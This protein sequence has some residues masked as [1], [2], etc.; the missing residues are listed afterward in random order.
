VWIVTIH[1]VHSDYA[2]PWIAQKGT[3]PGLDGLSAVVIF[4]RDWR[5]GKVAFCARKFELWPCFPACHTLPAL[6]LVVCSTEG[7]NKMP[8]A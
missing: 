2:C 8:S 3:L 6:A 7:R 1:L 4:P 5:P